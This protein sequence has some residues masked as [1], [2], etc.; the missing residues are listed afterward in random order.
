MELGAK[1]V[2]APH[3]CCSAMPMRSISFRAIPDGNADQAPF[4]PAGLHPRQHGAHEACVA[5]QNRIID[6]SRR[7]DPGHI[8][9]MVE[10]FV[11]AHGPVRVAVP[12]YTDRH[13]IIFEERKHAAVDGVLAG[14]GFVNADVPP[15]APDAY[16]EKALCASSTR[17]IAPLIIS[18]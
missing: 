6:E 3:G 14:E 1:F 13:E 5:R 9:R 17:L 7:R 8:V 15:H 10:N 18:T 11:E 2:P 16:P 4:E 12:R